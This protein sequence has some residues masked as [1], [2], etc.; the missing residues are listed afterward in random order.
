[1]NRI[2]V[3]QT[4]RVVPTA[5][6][7]RPAHVHLNCAEPCHPVIGRRGV[8]RACRPQQRLCHG[9]GGLMLLPPCWGRGDQEQRKQPSAGC[10]LRP[11]TLL[12]NCH[13]DV[14]TAADTAVCDSNAWEEGHPPTVPAP[15]V[16]RGEAKTAATRGRPCP[17]ASQFPSVPRQAFPSCWLGFFG[18]FVCLFVGVLGIEP[19]GTPRA[20]S[21]ALF[22][23]YFRTWSC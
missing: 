18:L 21:P 17:W 5:H 19:R 2:N 23:F 6:G 10:R 13:T 7:D 16:P 14:S 8:E 12:H 4:Q 15:H 3:P 1:M 20:P 22:T 11:R 9:C